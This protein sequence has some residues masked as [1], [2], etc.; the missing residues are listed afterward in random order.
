MIL[1]TGASGFVGH[2]LV[3]LLSGK[4]HIVHALY[5]RNEPGDELKRLPGVTWQQCDLLDIYAVEEVFEGIDEVYHC[6]AI[7]SFHPGHKER[8][9]HVNTESTTNVVNEA[10]E[11]GIRKLVYVSSVAALGRTEG[12]NK[13]ITEEEE[14]EESRHN[15]VYGQ[16]KYQAEMEVWRGIGEGLS[17]TIVNPGIILGEGNWDE[18]S[19]RLIKIVDREFPFYTEGI[20]GWVDVA[21]VAKA[22]YLLMQSDIEAERFIL[23]AGNYSYKEIFTLMAGALGRKPPHI[24]ASSWMTELL[25]RFMMLKTALTG[26]TATITKETT[27][28]AQKQCFY[29]NDK[30]IKHLPAFSYT[31][32]AQSVARMAA[33]YRN[34]VNK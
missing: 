4:G 9:L 28:T 27:R 26:E 25:W 8:L 33:A 15:S 12:S 18:G 24:K 30:L 11:R 34:S 19:A 13:Q 23:S 7:V 3:R 14:W 2:H 29:C 31:P 22:M 10:L 21:D 1:V 32:I 20:N 6:A 5:N 17:A 16:S